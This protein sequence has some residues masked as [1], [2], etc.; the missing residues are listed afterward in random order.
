MMSIS[1]KVNLIYCSILV[2]LINVG[3]NLVHRLRFLNSLSKLLI[4]DVLI[5]EL[6][7]INEM[8]NINKTT[9]CS[10]ST[11]PHKY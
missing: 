5:M 1:I 9:C 7:S 10:K 3:D 4:K 6:L 8:A 2:L 11:N